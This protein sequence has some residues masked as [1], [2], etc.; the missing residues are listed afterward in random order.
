MV[1][2]KAKHKGVSKVRLLIFSLIGVLIVVVGII[3][4]NTITKPILDLKGKD[5]ELLYIPSG[6]TFDDVK[7]LLCLK[8]WLIDDATFTMFA[9]WMNYISNVKAGCYEISNNMTAREL[10]SKLRSGNQKPFNVTFNNIRLLQQLAGKIAVVLEYDS[11]EYIQAMTDEALIKELGFTKETFPAMFIPNTYQFMWNT[12]GKEWVKRMHKEYERFWNEERQHKADSLGLSRVEV[13]T[14]ASIIE[15]ETNK[16]DE[17]PIIAGLYLNR[18]RIKMPMQACPTVK[19]ALGDFNKRRILSK[20]LLVDSPYN[21]YQN[22][23]LPPGPIRIP[24]IV[25]IDAVLNAKAHKYLY[26]CARPDG[27]GRHNFAATGAEHARN[28]RIYQQA[29]NKKK[30][31]R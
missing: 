15:E 30:I 27:S 4:M 10:V 24:S 26:M 12:D 17:Y 3:S 8:K 20:D 6:A 14:L 11:T 29:L 1:I 22:I 23:G 25:V 28:A 9:Q 18:L 19:F 7:Q 5:K 13:S 2:K 21:T 31:Y 16:V